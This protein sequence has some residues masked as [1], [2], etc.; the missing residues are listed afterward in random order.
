MVLVIVIGGGSGCGKT[1]LANA[2]ADAIIK[3]H[4][5]KV[6]VLAIDCFYR[7]IPQGTD[8]SEYNFDTPDAI[9]KLKIIDMIT[10]MKRGET[11]N[12][13][14]YSF[15]E[16]C[17]N[18]SVEVEPCDIVIM[19]GI[20]AMYMCD[21]YAKLQSVGIG[22]DNLFDICINIELSPDV[23]L[24]RRIRRDIKER[25]RD[26][27]SVIEQYERFVKPGYETYVKPYNRYAD[28][29][30]PNDRDSNVAVDCIVSWCNRKLSE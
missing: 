16:H 9:D 3:E 12:V 29:I 30:V 27:L 6:Y 7:S 23:S 11:V 26:A 13:P 14:D 28:I 2:I 17:V 8:P 4:N 21:Y 22:Y 18:G 5:R 10:S 19:E 1:T 15:V 20:F 24:A 25:G